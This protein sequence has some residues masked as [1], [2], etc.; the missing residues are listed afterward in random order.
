MWRHGDR[1]SRGTQDD[2]S[3]SAVCAVPANPDLVGQ[4]PL[5]TVPQNMTYLGQILEPHLGFC[6]ISKNKK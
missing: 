5:L 6:L 4:V 3:P 1:A 2:S